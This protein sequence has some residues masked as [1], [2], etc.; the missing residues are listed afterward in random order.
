MKFLIIVLSIYDMIQK[1]S[2]IYCLTP[3]PGIDILQKGI[4]ITIFD[5]LPEEMSKPIG[6]KRNI[7]DFT[8]DEN[9]KWKN[10]NQKEF[11]L[12]DQVESIVHIPVGITNVKTEIQTSFSETKKSRALNVELTYEDG[13][14]S[15]SLSSK[16]NMR[17]INDHNKTLSIVSAHVSATKVDLIP[18]LNI[19]AG[20]YMKEFINK[21]L[22]NNYTE[23]PSKYQEFF[24]TFGTHYFSSARF[25]GIIK[26]EIFTESEYVSKSTQSYLETQAKASYMAILSAKGGHTSDDTKVDNTYESKSTASAFY[27]GGD[28]RFLKSQND[29]NKWIDS[30]S[31]E[32]WIFG[33]HLIPIM[34][35][36][37]NGT[38]RDAF[39]TAYAVKLDKAFLDELSLSL[40][41]LKKNSANNSEMIANLTREVETLKNEV[42]PSHSEVKKLGDTIDKLW[43]PKIVIKKN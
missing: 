22:Q 3:P 37:P 36:L 2:S 9:K 4:D 15:N 42:I 30:I 23:N 13:Q 32:P 34:N 5:L 25:G 21:Y 19:K 6:I 41:Y 1:S 31:K 17:E 28:T 16:K 26:V 20:T 18:Y 39:N 14:F 11:D 27:Y 29:T 24:D 43:G 33:G 7:F 8:C 12:P 38:N 10:E 35:F 40:T